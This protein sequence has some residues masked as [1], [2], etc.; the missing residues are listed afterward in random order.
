[1]ELSEL[2]KKIVR[3]LCTD[4][5]ISVTDLTKKLGVSRITIAQRIRSLTKELGLLFTLEL[6]YDTLGFSR[7]HVMYLNF[8]KK[9]NPAELKRLFENDNIVQLAVAT[10]GDFDLI[11]FAITKTSKEY[12]NWEIKQF[13]SMARYGVAIHSSETTIA[14][15]GFLPLD[16]EIIARSNTKDVY[17][18]ILIALNGNSRMPIRELA[19]QVGMHE[20]TVRYHLAKMEKEKIIKRYTAIIT[21]PPLK[22]NIVYFANYSVKEG[23]EKRIMQ[24]R[25]IMY[26]KKTSEFP[27]VSEFQLMFSMTGSEISFT[28]ACYDDKKK[29]FESSVATHARVYRIDSPIVKSAIVTEVIKGI[30]PIRNIDIKASYDTSRP[31]LE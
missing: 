27:V 9:P 18:K 16:N 22:H 20:D 15:I 29:G 6:D 1:M 2:G 5:R 8:A 4:S 19:E 17:K 26:F 7:Q 31:G 24:E 10:K 28:W 13:I 23:I 30:A 12:F 3:E 14:H 21:K 25:E 11:L